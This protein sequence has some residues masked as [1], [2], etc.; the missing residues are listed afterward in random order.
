MQRFFGEAVYYRS[1]DNQ[2]A[3]WVF[4]AS[5][6][7][8]FLEP[9]EA[10]SAGAAVVVVPKTLVLERLDAPNIGCKELMSPWGVCR[11]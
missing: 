6:Q 5:C 11:E 10:C 9:N 3:G 2:A 7:Q 1:A 4:G 8:I